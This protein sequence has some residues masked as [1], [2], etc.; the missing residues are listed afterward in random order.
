MDKLFSAGGEMSTNSGKNLPRRASWG[1]LIT[2]TPAKLLARSPIC[3]SAGAGRQT[4]PYVNHPRSPNHLNRQNSITTYRLTSVTQEARLK[5]ALDPHLE[6][7]W[8]SAFRC[9]G[10][11]LGAPKLRTVRMPVA[12]RTGSGLAQNTSERPL[13]I[14]DTYQ[15]M[16]K[17]LRVC[18]LRR[19][20]SLRPL[21]CWRL[22]GRLTEFFSCASLVR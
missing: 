5:S 7:N 17:L 11:A 8:Q 13:N 3:A 15:Q 20:E 1:Y 21:R 12:F 6:G 16:S 18:Q 9:P 4:W 19:T 2:G 22:Q 10:Q 14:L